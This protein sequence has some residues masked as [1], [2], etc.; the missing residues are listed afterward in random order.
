MPASHLRMPRKTAHQPGG[1][2]GTSGRDRHL[3]RRVFIS[4]AHSDEDVARTI[5]AYREAF[6]V[7]RFAL[8]APAVDAMLLGEVN[9][10]VFRRA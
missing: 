5:D 7:L 2:G 3:R 8:D 6:K 4:L 10:L 9:E 1:G